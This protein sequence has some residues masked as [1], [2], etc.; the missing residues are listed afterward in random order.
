MVNIFMHVNSQDDDGTCKHWVCAVT[1]DTGGS[2]GDDVTGRRT[3]HGGTIN[4][5]L[6]VLFNYF[7]I[8]P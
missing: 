5:V 7:V 3:R 8:S 6:H 4:A 2:G 1:D